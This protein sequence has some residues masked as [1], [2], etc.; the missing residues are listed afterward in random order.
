MYG[1]WG[2]VFF[3]KLL[4]ETPQTRPT[5]SKQGGKK[6]RLGPTHHQRKL[7]LLFLL[8]VKI[9]M[10]LLSESFATVNE[11]FVPMQVPYIT[12]KS[13]T[14]VQNLFDSFETWT[15]QVN[16]NELELK[17]ETTTGFTVPEAVNVDTPS[18][19]C[20]GMLYVATGT[21]TT[22]L[23]IPDSVDVT[24][25]HVLRFNNGLLTSYNVFDLD[26]VIDT[27]NTSGS[28][29][30]V[31]EFQLPL[32]SGGSYDFYVY[33]GDDSFDHITSWNQG[34]TLH[35]YSSQGVYNIKIVGELVGWRFAF[36]GDRFKML[37]IQ[38]W[39]DGFIMGTNQ[40]G[41]FQGC[42][43]MTVET[44]RAPN[45]SATTILDYA[46]DNC[47]LLAV[48]D[49]NNWDV[50]NVTS[51][52]YMLQNSDF[53]A[54]IGNWDVG[55][56][57]CMTGMFQG[58]YNFNQPL[59]HWDTSSVLDMALMFNSCSVFDQP[60]GNWDVSSVTSFY[61]MFN[62]AYDFNQPLERWNVS[63]AVDMES[64]FNDAS[65]FNQPLNKWDV[66]NVKYMGYMLYL[67]RFNQPLHLWNVKKV[68]QMYYTF[69]NT[70]FNQNLNLWQTNSLQDIEGTFESCYSYNQPMNNWNTSNI[71]YMYATFYSCFQ[72]NQPLDNWVT[73]N[74]D[75]MGGL[76]AFTAFNFSIDNWDTSSV[77]NLSGMF[78]A[79]YTF[80][81]PLNSWDTSNVEFMSVLFYEAYNF[82]QPLYNWDVTKVL[83][84]DSMFTYTNFKR[85]IANWKLTSCIALDG[86]F[87][88]VDM[89][90]PNSDDNQN[91]YN[92]LLL[93]WGN[94]PIL[95][96]LQ[97]NLNFDGGNSKYTT[98]VAGT[99][100][101]NLINI[102]NWSILDAGGV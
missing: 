78:R 52:M 23:V 97:D 15:S 67:S 93:S 59:I 64:M 55:Q 39:F 81:Q 42:S 89:N 100:R 76:F 40:G 84:A 94:S 2:A 80:N 7:V 91:N 60:L 87:T 102:R 51:M 29:S 33:W 46:F 83:Y 45:L 17:M 19:N 54:A 21:E 6:A 63:S 24:Y 90:N 96:G 10:S 74:V 31:N 101:A 35:P 38:D 77:H 12:V 36:G 9:K 1:L 70:P 62:Y 79:C 13:A 53:N 5:F 57:L 88:G 14:V 71:L 95:E 22:V 41:Y 28:S 25:P 73:S 34:E 86:M 4:A 65:S 58:C 66:R 69:S 61:G 72:F 18:L 27:R 37:T 75:D 16:L 32:I 11:A 82:N 47:F 44:T 48:T 20:N 8:T 98:V 85:S 30:A 68:E 92:A 26:I 3:A 43:N 56:V 49:W 50:S 99:A